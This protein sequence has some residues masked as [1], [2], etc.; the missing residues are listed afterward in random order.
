MKILAI[1]LLALF[2][3]DSDPDLSL[4]AKLVGSWKL[5]EVVFESD[6]M[7]MISPI[8]KSYQVLLE[9]KSDGVCTY[10][11]KEVLQQAEW[12]LVGT[13]LLVSQSGRPIAELLISFQDKDNSWTYL[14]TRLDLVKDSNLPANH[15]LLDF[16]HTV[17]LANQKQLTGVSY[18]DVYFRMTKQEIAK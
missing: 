8:P 5:N 17:A 14:A 3:H 7:R 9:L 2:C 13:T 10:L 12:K 16:V 18:L 1:A 11:E 4:A 15:S 6:G